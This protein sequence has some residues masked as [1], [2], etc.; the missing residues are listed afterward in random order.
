MTTHASKWTSEERQNKQ[1]CIRSHTHTVST[2][3]NGSVLADCLLGSCEEKSIEY[4]VYAFQ[5]QRRPRTL[6]VCFQS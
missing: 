2:L 4:Y 5:C 3:L 6:T 1:P